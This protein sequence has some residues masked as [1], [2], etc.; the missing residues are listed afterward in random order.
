MPFTSTEIAELQALIAAS[1][2]GP[3]VVGEFRRQFPG[4]SVT[5]C[6]DTDMAAEQP[7]AQF[8]RVDLYF[9]DGRDH[10]WQIT[11]DPALATGVVLARRRGRA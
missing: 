9:V 4:R 7:F 8:P 11:G 10:C 2:G 6:D 1:D 5:R 3:Q